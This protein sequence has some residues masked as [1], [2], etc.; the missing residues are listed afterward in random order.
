MQQKNNDDLLVSFMTVVTMVC[1]ISEENW[2]EYDVW[3]GIKF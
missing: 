2:F 3:K 1:G